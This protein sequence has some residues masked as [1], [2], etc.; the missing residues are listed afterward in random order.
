MAQRSWFRWLL[1]FLT[2]CAVFV[3]PERGTALPAP[4][5]T[6]SGIVTVDGKPL[7]DV[8]VVLHVGRPIPLTA[9]TD[10]EGRFWFHG[11]PLEADLRAAVMIGNPEHCANFMLRA[12]DGA[13]LLNQFHDGHDGVMQYDVFRLTGAEPSV[14]LAFSPRRAA[15][16]E[17]VCGGQLATIIG[18]DGPDVLIGGEDSDVIVGGKGNDQLR[19]K[20]GAD[21]LCGEGGRDHI[22]G[23]FGADWIDGGPGSDHTLRGG[24]GRDV[25]LG[26][27][28]DDSA[29]GYEGRDVVWGQQGDDMLAGGNE[30][31]WIRGHTGDDIVKGGRGP[32]ILIGGAGTD[33]AR[34]GFGADEC[35]AEIRIRC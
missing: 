33:T 32:D 24:W 1:S 18:T 6:V 7:I 21:F 29:S 27:A 23:E 22:N 15:G 11:V 28:G 5:G 25:I 20:Q 17:R 19:G 9:C 34:G 14:A 4:S 16:H 8:E 2:A 12:P 31:D 3:V 13:Q 30:R 35:Q 10:D 26:R